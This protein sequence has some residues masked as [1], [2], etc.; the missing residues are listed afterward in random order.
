MSHAKRYGSE[1]QQHKRN[2]CSVQHTIRPRDLSL[3]SAL[4]KV[5]LFFHKSLCVSLLKK[6][7]SASEI[8]DKSLWVPKN[9]HDKP[10]WHLIPEATNGHCPSISSGFC[11]YKIIIIII[12]LFL[13]N[14]QARVESTWALKAWMSWLKR[15]FSLYW[16]ESTSSVLETCGHRFIAHFCKK[17]KTKQMA[18]S[19][20]L[21]K[22]KKK[23]KTLYPNNKLGKKWTYL[24]AF[25]FEL[26]F[27]FLLL[28]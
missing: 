26:S 13:N 25:S 23:N 27:R 24:P 12:I 7:I 2:K 1:E 17:K 9:L 6:L 15:H 4:G 18:C 8:P 14:D 16:Q 3:A 22:A 11:S 19:V 28:D 20:Q 10:Y 5:M 21:Q